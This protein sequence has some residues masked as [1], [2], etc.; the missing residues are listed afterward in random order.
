MGDGWLGFLDVGYLSFRERLRN[1][2]WDFCFCCRLRIYLPYL[3][4]VSI[5]IFIFPSLSPPPPHHHHQLTPL[6]HRYSYSNTQHS[7]PA[8]T[9]HL[10]LSSIVGAKTLSRPLEQKNPCTPPDAAPAPLHGP[11]NPLTLGRGNRE[12]GVGGDA[13]KWLLGSCAL[14]AGLKLAIR[15]NIVLV[16]PESSREISSAGRMVRKTRV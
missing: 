3:S 12:H 6:L 9:I 11:D 15:F 14:F 16:Q 5:S 2:R 13:G 7:I 10:P 8:H 4:T 1:F